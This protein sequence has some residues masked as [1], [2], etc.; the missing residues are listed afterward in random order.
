MVDG[1]TQPGPDDLITGSN[2]LASGLFVFQSSG[3]TRLEY[4]VPIN[5]D[6]PESIDLTR[7][8]TVSSF[9]LYDF[10]TSDT[11]TATNGYNKLINSS[12]GITGTVP[13]IQ[14]YTGQILYLDYR[15]PITRS[16][17]QNEKINIV[18]NF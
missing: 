1:S 7:I 16:A 5:S 14:P 2:S 15:S 13:E 11:I 17:G 6:A 3:T 12:T 10:N 4:I 8:D 9:K 18:I